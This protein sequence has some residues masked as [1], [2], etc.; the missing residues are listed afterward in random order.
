VIKDI[1]TFPLRAG[2]QVVGRLLSAADTT[3]TL[4]RHVVESV[5]PSPPRPSGEG[6][7]ARGQEGE[8]PEQARPVRNRA[9]FPA[10]APEPAPAPEP[11]HV[12]EEPV[13]VA[14]VADEGAED[15]VGAQ[16]TIAEP[17]EGYRRMKASDVVAA[18]D[19]ATREQL[20]VVQLYE[21]STRSRK[22][23]LQAVERELKVASSPATRRR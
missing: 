7:R 14:E 9:P 20:A 15:G 16:V 5:R 22:S 3:F 10:S 2:A 4:A 6:E 1:A 13:L 21:T 19:G 8:H 17:W 12:S 18:L 23:V 11:A